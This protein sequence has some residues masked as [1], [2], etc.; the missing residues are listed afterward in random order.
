M[1]VKALP[2]LAYAP[3]II[4]IELFPHGMWLLLANLLDPEL[5]RLAE[6]QS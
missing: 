5:F 1:I 3:L 6:T 2:L 4:A